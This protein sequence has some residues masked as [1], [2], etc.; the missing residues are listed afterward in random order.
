[1]NLLVN[2]PMYSKSKVA[3][4]L[5]YLLRSPSTK[6]S[7]QPP[8]YKI[9]TMPQQ[10]AEAL[11]WTENTLNPIQYQP[12]G[13]DIET[14]GL[15]LTEDKIVG[16]SVYTPW[17]NTSYYCPLAHTNGDNFSNPP[18]TVSVEAEISQIFHNH[19]VIPIH[20]NGYEFDEI[21]LRRAGYKL[22]IA[23]DSYI[24]AK[25][26][27]LQN[28]SLKD[29]SLDMGIMSFRDIIKY[30]DLE[31]PAGKT[32]ADLEIS[33]E[34]NAHNA[35]LPSKALKYAADDAYNAYHLFSEIL[36]ILVNTIGESAAFTTTID[37]TYHAN[38]LVRNSYVGYDVDNELLTKFATEF[39]HDVTRLEESL[40]SEIK[41]K[42]G[43]NTLSSS[44]E[45]NSLFALT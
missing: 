22:P 27:C 33:Y 15:S 38:Y 44:E 37:Q 42:M 17:N 14:T 11:A 34:P 28:L 21:I 23:L 24:L 3:K 41:T 39:E 18:G 32:F 7:R 36:Q 10:L 1:M 9:I 19:K 8:Q 30:S 26:A 13:F 6:E 2:H 45:Q 35:P 4:A 16:F 5:K 40:R 29:L 43:W 20:H 31:I 12:I 25:Q